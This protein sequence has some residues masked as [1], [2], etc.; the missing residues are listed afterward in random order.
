M[1]TEEEL[2]RTRADHTQKNG[3]GG[4]WSRVHSH[5]IIQWTL[6]YLGAALALAHGQEL[7]AHAFH[8]PDIVSRVFIVA[9]I[10]GV[11][12]VLTLG[13]YHGHRGLKHVSAGELTIISV[14]LLFVALFFTIALR[15]AEWGAEQAAS[16]PAASHSAADRDAATVPER[17]PNSI[18]VLPFVNISS[19]A[20]QEYF[21]D[22]LSEE[23]MNQLAQ[24]A[25]LRVTAR[26]S[27]FAF[28]GTTENVS[29]IGEQLNV[30]NVLEGSVRKAGDRVLI[31][32]QLVDTANGFH[33]WSNSFNRALDDIFAVQEEI[34]REVAGALK[35]TLGIDEDLRI[36]GGT[37]NVEAYQLYLDATQRTGVGLQFAR[38]DEQLKLIDQAL[39]FDP[40]FA[41]AWARKSDL[42]RQLLLDAARNADELRA[43][44]EAAARRAAEIAPSSVI[45]L[46]TLARVASF[47]GDWSEAEAQYRQALAIGDLGT[48]GT[49]Y[50]LLKLVVGH[51]EEA[52]EQ[53]EAQKTRDPLN[54][55]LAGFLAATYD[56]VGDRQA[57]FAEYTRGSTLIRNWISGGFNFAIT[58]HGIAEYV[59]GA[60][61]P[62]AFGPF[63]NVATA[64]VR[65][66]IENWTDPP[67]ALAA[68]RKAYAA[69]D[70][71]PATARSLIRLTLG[72]AAARFG[73]PELALKAFEDSM[74]W[75]PE[76]LYLIWRPVFRDMRQLPRFKQFARDTGL[77]AYWRE[78]GWPDLCR[79][80]GED[81]L[82]CE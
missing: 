76:Q 56:S 47:R 44:A 52:R 7:V 53:L 18:A 5:K 8:W 79:P 21:A 81:D 15:P 20:E 24:I 78:Y 31:T 49:D 80:V 9:L 57:A 40:N 42:H 27:S 82:T 74:Q 25:E 34:A 41:L 54:D 65:P 4:F 72:S 22:G 11:P 45:A 63:Q 36:V 58:N 66:I 19:D 59:P 69:L 35:V 23:L 33:L 12:I 60:N 13:W 61:G 6:G 70:T 26:T 14:L 16:E 77:V 67:T 32:A 48:R 68:V 62:P 75:S 51:L 2:E 37:R 3:D 71:V 17:P 1:G 38:I 43:A 46:G 29:R 28:K 30:A 55:S 39:V 10:G 73:D 64:L 50:G